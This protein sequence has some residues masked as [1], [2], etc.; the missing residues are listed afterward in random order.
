MKAPITQEELDYRDNLTNRAN[1]ISN[2]NGLFSDVEDKSRRLT[3]LKSL[4][5]SL[6]LGDEVLDV[7]QKEIEAAE[8]AARKAKEAEEAEAA[9]S[10]AEASGSGGPQ[11]EDTS[12][13]D[14]DLAPMPDSEVEEA[15]EDSK[16]EEESEE[17]KTILM[18]EQTIFEESDDLPTPEEADDKRDF[19]ENL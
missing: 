15:L 12:D 10:A 13:D 9:A 11:E 14:L 5:N 7:I 19:S 16:E 3:I 6:H 18:E 2:I 17:S 8:E 1:A 4:I